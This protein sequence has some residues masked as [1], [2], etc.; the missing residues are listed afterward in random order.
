MNRTEKLTVDLHLHTNFSDGK[1]PVAELVDLYGK[2]GFDAIAITDHLCKQKNFLGF[3]ARVLNITLTEKNWK[4]Y[5]DEI[6]KAKNLAWRN[7]RMIVFT[8]V[9]YTHNTFD[10]QRNAHMLAID[11]KDFISPELDEENWLKEAR[12]LDAL[13]VGAHPMK[14]KDAKSQTYYLIDNLE[15]FS[16]LIDV[17][18]VANGRVFSRE[19]LRKPLSLI[20]SSDLHS[21]KGWR[22]WRT[23]IECEKDPQAIKEFFRDKTSPR[24]FVFID[25]NVES[26]KNKISLGAKKIVSVLSETIHQNQNTCSSFNL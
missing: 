3:G 23:Q 17:W 14:L 7:Y 16:P 25:G 19:M 4:A 20:A 22:A 2:A 9:E 21:P 18:E 24:E 5:I 6:E 10:H 8:G 12:K 11:V 13:T 26:I 15:K 1:L